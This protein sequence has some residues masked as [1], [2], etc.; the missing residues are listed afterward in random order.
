MKIAYRAILEI[1]GVDN[2]GEFGEEAQRKLANGF[3]PV[4]PPFLRAAKTRGEKELP[5][6]KAHEERLWVGLSVRRIFPGTFFCSHYSKA[7]PFPL[8]IS[9]K[10]RGKVPI[11]GH[12]LLWAKFRKEEDSECVKETPEVS[13]EC[14]AFIR[15]LDVLTAL[16]TELPV[17]LP[18]L[19]VVADYMEEDERLKEQ[20]GDVEWPQTVAKIQWAIGNPI[21]AAAGSFTNWGKSLLGIK[22]EEETKSGSP[23]A[24]LMGIFES[25][26]RLAPAVPGLLKV[27][28]E[29]VEMALAKSEKVSRPTRL[30]DKKKDRAS[31]RGF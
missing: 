18:D 2:L 11:T 10:F 28:E 12:P 21:T 29:F 15:D 14:K 7:I 20:Y 9:L 13:A 8:W 30:A 19:D 1:L 16:A 4:S 17:M 6:L 22:V 5:R 27:E 31:C 3:P 25:V 23:M 24:A 26:K